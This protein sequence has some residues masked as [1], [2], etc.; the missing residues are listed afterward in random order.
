MQVFILPSPRWRG[1]LRGQ[2]HPQSS[3]QLG[4]TLPPPMCSSTPASLLLPWEYSP[5][6]HIAITTSFEMESDHETLLFQPFSCS[7]WLLS[8][9]SLP[10]MGHKTLV[11]QSGTSLAVSF[12][13]QLACLSCSSYTLLLHI[14]PVSCAFTCA[15]PC[16]SGLPLFNNANYSFKSGS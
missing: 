9:L 3:C 5:L 14:Y 4:Y 12:I 15:V 2:L 10:S 7:P 1:R 6:G 13:V 16:L 8:W 11:V